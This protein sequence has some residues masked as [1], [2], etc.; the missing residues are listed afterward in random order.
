MT[1][2]ILIMPWDGYT[3]VVVLYWLP[4]PRTQNCIAVKALSTE[5]TS[6]T[7][8]SWQ[9]VGYVT[10]SKRKPECNIFYILH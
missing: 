10:G 2:E 9:Q 4:V 8:R 1:W 5:D 7:H 3:Y 6:M